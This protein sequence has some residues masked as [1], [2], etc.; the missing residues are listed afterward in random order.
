[1]RKMIKMRISAIIIITLFISAPLFSQEWEVPADRKGRLSPFQFDDQSR[2]D[3]ER[4][5]N[6]NCKS[7][8]GT[9]GKGNFQ[10]TLVPVPADPASEKIQ[11]NLDGELFYKISTGR[12]PMPGFRSSLSATELWNVISFI[13]IFKK[14]YIQA[15]APVIRSSAYPGA[16]IGVTLLHGPADNEIT[17]LA[18]AVSEK[19]KVPVTGAGVRLFVKRTFGR[20]EVDEERTTDLNGMAVFTI[21]EGMP[22]DSA[23]NLQVSVVF[24]D[25]AAFGQISRDTVIKTGTTTSP[26]GLT[27]KRAMW[28]ISRKAPVWILITY[29]FGVLGVWG[30]IFLIMFR[31]RDIYII[32]KHI[33]AK[34]ESEELKS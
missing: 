15:I 4:L 22:G 5:Y 19:T 2:K 13:R 16:V 3:G 11:K 29:T 25:E 9:P 14:D 10:A 33:S 24:T 30:F 17:M 8:H 27:A 32:G 20:M 12:G 1:M 28:N 23:G 6:L 18:E 26:V 34:K 21:P 7:C 31:L